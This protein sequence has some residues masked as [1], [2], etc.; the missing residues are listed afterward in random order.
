MKCG[1]AT[2]QLMNLKRTNPQQSRRLQV[3]ALPAFKNSPN[4]S[5]RRRCGTCR[6][7]PEMTRFLRRRP[8]LTFTSSLLSFLHC[9]HGALDEMWEVPGRIFL[10]NFT[11][12][13]LRE[14][15]TKSGSLGPQTSARLLWDAR[16]PPASA[17]YLLSQFIAACPKA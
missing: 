15:G 16:A 11:I 14:T 12:R 4:S 5:S 10:E 2:S 3:P 8:D 7:A 17:S 9:G 13:Y 1:D 6:S